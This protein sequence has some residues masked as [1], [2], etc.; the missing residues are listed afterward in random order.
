MFVNRDS[1]GDAR[2]PAPD[3][4]ICAEEFERRS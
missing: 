2:S 3:F 4:E 1:L